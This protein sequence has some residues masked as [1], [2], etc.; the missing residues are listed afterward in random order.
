MFPLEWVE[1][2]VWTKQNATETPSSTILLYIYMFVLEVNIDVLQIC[3][4]VNRIDDGTY[5]LPS[6]WVG[7]NLAITW[8]VIGAK[9]LRCASQ[10]KHDKTM[11]N[12]G[13]VTMG[14]VTQDNSLSIPIS[15]G[16]LSRSHKTGVYMGIVTL[17]IYHISRY[18]VT[19]IELCSKPCL[20][21]DYSGLYYAL[22]V[23]GY[24]H[25]WTG[26]PSLNQTEIQ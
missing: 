6:V 4:L 9:K 21:D 17:V 13:I 16:W 15:M 2:T 23:L 12:P 8:Y 11:V 5:S 3:S 10:I 18:Q 20:F 7:W 22:Y 19:S 24:H 14:I 25:P 1:T 26:S